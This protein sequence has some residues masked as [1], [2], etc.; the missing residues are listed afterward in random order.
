[1]AVLY[2][3]FY[4]L[5]HNTVDILWHPLGLY[6]ASKPDNNFNQ[7]VVHRRPFAAAVPEINNIRIVL[8]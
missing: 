8:I 5:P 2:T 1:M 3:N 6:P 7:F 4:S